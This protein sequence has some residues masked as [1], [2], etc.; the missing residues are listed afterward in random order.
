MF[1]K[2][3][4]AATEVPKRVL[5]D[6]AR[7]GMFSVINVISAVAQ[8]FVQP[9]IEG[10]GLMGLVGAAVIAGVK[11]DAKFVGYELSKELG[12]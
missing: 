9:M 4:A 11:D 10:G 12:A 5:M 2:L 8:T 7:I 6:A 3:S 1:D